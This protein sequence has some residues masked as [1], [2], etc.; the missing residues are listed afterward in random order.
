[1]TADIEM[2]CHECE[3]PWQEGEWQDQPEWPGSQQIN[4]CPCG[5]T[6]FYVLRIKP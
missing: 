2:I 3:A 5:S 6:S 1:M 4:V